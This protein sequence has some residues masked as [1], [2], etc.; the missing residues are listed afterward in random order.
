MSLYRCLFISVVEAPLDNMKVLSSTFDRSFTNDAC[1]SIKGPG[2]EDL[3]GE[4]HNAVRPKGPVVAGKI[5]NA[6][7][8]I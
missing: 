2:F 4:I 5:R 3:P 1:G 8:R 6:D 7:R